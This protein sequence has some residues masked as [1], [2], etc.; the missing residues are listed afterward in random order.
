MDEIELL[1]WKIVKDG[2]KCP[3]N[4]AVLLRRLFSSEKVKWGQRIL[5]NF[6][7]NWLKQRNA[8]QQSNNEATFTTKNEQIANANEKFHTYIEFSQ[9]GSYDSDRIVR[10]VFKRVKP[11]VTVNA[12]GMK[13][14]YRPRHG[15]KNNVLLQKYSK[16]ER[17]V[18][19]PTLSSRYSERLLNRNRKCLINCRCLNSECDSKEPPKIAKTANDYSELKSFKKPFRCEKPPSLAKLLSIVSSNLSQNNKIP[20]NY[21]SAAITSKRLTCQICA[22]SITNRLTCQ[23]R[24]GLKHLCVKASISWLNKCLLCSQKGKEFKTL[25]S[26]TMWKHVE[27]KHNITKVQ[28]GVHYFDRSTEC[29]E[30]IKSVKTL[31]FPL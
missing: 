24:H 28:S 4:E 25:Y 7:R 11:Y 12:D 27:R 22:Y 30:E 31:A 21:K 19:S 16:L 20:Q 10:H 29:L 6:D 8:L 3:L 9:K 23:V 26:D 13:E 15:K 18:K 14:F 17:I 1:I 5:K 2:W